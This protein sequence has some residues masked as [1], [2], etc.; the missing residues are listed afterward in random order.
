M[1]LSLALST[2][3]PLPPELRA[4]AP[5]EW[6]GLRRDQVKLLVLNRTTGSIT[7]SRF[8][9]IGDFLAPGDLLVLNS[10]R[11]LPSAVPARRHDGTTVQLRPAIR[12]D[13]RWDSL[14]VLP[15]P[16]HSNVDLVAGEILTLGDGL[17]AR[18]VGRR[19]DIP[20]LWQL[21]LGVD[22]TD[23]IL[24]EGEPIRYSYIRGAV[25]L[26]FYQTVY[27]DRPGSAEMPSAGRPF[28]WELLTALRAAGVDAAAIV[29]HTG[30]SSYQ[31]D[32]FDAEH[33]LHE[34]WYEVS[35]ATA[36]AVKSAQRVVA[37]GTTVVRALLS[38]TDAS[39]MVRA[40]AGWTSLAVGPGTDAG[41]IDGLVTGLHEPAASHFDLMR[42]LVPESLLLRAYEEAVARRYLWHEFGDAMLIL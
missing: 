13:G 3:T 2:A 12:R 42:A 30:L 8:D 33:H 26:D 25:P 28:S 27:A 6:R 20:L 10:S 40:G 4:A 31:D 17:P 41:S 9:R 24:S 36:A 22:G 11:T 19:P 1:A 38:S 21:E 35:D 32:A 29:L 15:V 39:G 23:S 5:P 14:A 7:H 34:E 18:V 37:V 16:P